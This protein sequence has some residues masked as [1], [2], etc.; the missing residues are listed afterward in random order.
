MRTL[1]LAA[2][3]AFCAPPAAAQTAGFGQVSLPQLR[4][5]AA[6]AASAPG[7][8]V[9]PAA[10]AYERLTAGHLAAQTARHELLSFTQNLAQHKAFAA[11]WTK[12]LARA[13][14]T[15]GQP[16]YDLLS[17]L[18]YSGNEGLVIR[19]FM[20]EPR[21][22]KPKDEAD[23][24]ANMEKIAKLAGKNG[25]P[26]FAAFLLDFNW[27]LP[28][29]SLYYTTPAKARPEEEIRLRFLRY[30]GKLDTSILTEKAGVK[31]LQTVDDYLTVYLGPQAHVVQRSANTRKELDERMDELKKLIAGQG[32][33]FL[34]AVVREMPPGSWRKF[35][36]DLY[37]LL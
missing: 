22:F 26:V 20:A 1:A 25:L 21:Q 11:M 27:H 9:A 2:A 35:E 3:A 24:I 14:F 36:A 5:A 13:G 19:D 30:E 29:Y 7:A 10:L 6:S 12:I 32:G 15:P 17:V 37:F 34:D 28:T 33:K 23:R 16:K 18:P 4:R 8:P 31:V